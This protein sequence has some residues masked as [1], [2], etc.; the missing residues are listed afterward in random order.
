MEPRRARAF[1]ICLRWQLALGK[2]ANSPS[3]FYFFK[4]VNLPRWKISPTK[5]PHC[6]CK[7]L[8]GIGRAL[9]D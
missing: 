7:R 5:M 6:D 4:T 2:E 8:I 9:A 1:V 3:D